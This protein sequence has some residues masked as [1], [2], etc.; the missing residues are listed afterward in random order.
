MLKLTNVL[1][2]TLKLRFQNKTD[3]GN[4]KKGYEIFT[5]CSFKFN[6]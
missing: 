1:V 4:L 6:Y 5:T 3:T 2:K